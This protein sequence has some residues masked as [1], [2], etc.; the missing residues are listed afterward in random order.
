VG[1]Y[2]AKLFAPQSEAELLARAERLAGRRFAEVAG[3]V[4]MVVPPDLRGHKGWVGHLVERALGASA[5]S[6]AEPDF[7]EI[8]VELKTL[9]VDRSGKPLETTFVCTVPLSEVGETAWEDSRLR[10]KLARVLWVPILGERQVPMA[11]RR[12]GSPLLWSPSESQARAL[13]ADWE[14]LAGLIG[15]GDLEAI[16][17]RLGEVMQLRPKAANAAVRRRTIDAEGE[18]SETLPRGFY[19]R[20]HFTAA[21]L[22]AGFEPAP[23]GA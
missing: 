3:E 13:K 8:G 21:I 16:N 15:R 10:H 11:E 7:V 23:A 1:G 14:Q 20:T 17:G 9:P 12:I 22:K 6:R 18:L 2:Q 19:L 5:A 4:G